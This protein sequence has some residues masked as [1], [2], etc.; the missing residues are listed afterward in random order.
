MLR[1]V[2]ASTLVALLM[3]CPF[4][5]GAVDVGHGTTHGHTSCATLPERVHGST[6]CPESCDNCICDG[7]VRTEDTRAP[8]PQMMQL[9]VAFAIPSGPPFRLAP[10]LA[11]NGSPPGV[12]D[13]G[14]HSTIRARLQNYRC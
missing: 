14:D 3:Y 8:E 11:Q 2:V 4:I 6:H 10:H 13:P 9:P 7:A 12:L 5:C 1:R